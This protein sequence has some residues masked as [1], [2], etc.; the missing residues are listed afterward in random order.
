MIEV[1]L[2]PNGDSLHVVHVH[3]HRQPVHPLLLVHHL[4]PHLLKN[5]QC[6]ERLTEWAHPEELSV[7]VTRFVIFGIVHQLNLGKIHTV[8]VRLQNLLELKDK[9]CQDTVWRVT[10]CYPYC[11]SNYFFT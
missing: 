4:L 7:V 10:L 5:H 1:V 3:F 6:Q 8:V 11:F 2:L 9:T